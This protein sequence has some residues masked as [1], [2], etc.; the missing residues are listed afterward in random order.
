MLDELYEYLL[1]V[2]LGFG[3]FMLVQ[4]PVDRLVDATTGLGP[5]LTMYTVA[6]IGSVISVALAVLVLRLIRTIINDNEQQT[7]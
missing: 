3:L 1:L 7:E 5:V 2:L 6:G 4:V